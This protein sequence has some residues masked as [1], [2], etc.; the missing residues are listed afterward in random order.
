[1]ELDVLPTNLYVD[2]Q[3]IFKNSVI[4][5]VSLSIRLLRAVKSDFEIDFIRKA[6]VSTK[7]RTMG[8][9]PQAG[10]LSEP[11]RPRLSGRDS[12]KSTPHKS[13]YE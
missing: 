5:D 6:P 13:L 12:V 1:M 7:R 2:Y 8:F 9:E 11:F 10:Q 4:K 3:N